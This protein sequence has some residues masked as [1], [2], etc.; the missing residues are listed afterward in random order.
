MKK[1][2]VAA[3]IGFH[4]TL[5]QSFIFG[6]PIDYFQGINNLPVLRETRYRHISSHDRVLG[7][8]GDFV[9]VKTGERFVLAE[10]QGPGIVT[11][12][13]LTF[14]CKDPFALR[15]VVLRMFWDGEKEPSVQSPIGDF[16]G[17]GFAEYVHFTSYLIGMSSGGFYSFFPMPFSKGAKIEIENNADTL[18]DGFYFNIGYQETKSLPKNM[19]RFH[20][21]WR[22]EKLSKKSGDYTILEARGRGHYVGTVLSMQG[23]KKG[24]L[25]FLE[26]DEKFYVDGE[27]VPSV[28]GTGTEDYFLSGYYFNKGTFGGPLH[29]CLIKDRENA[30]ISAYRFHTA[31]AI[32]FTKSIHVQIEHGVRT[33]LPVRA[34]YSSVAYWYQ[35]E[36]HRPFE[37]LPLPE[38]RIPLT[39]K[40]LGW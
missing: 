26:G 18:I 17:V 12:I 4:L 6:D 23:Y 2:M 31:D 3:L 14:T 35:Q 27:T 20:A 24:D 34:D 7:G 28:L 15:K 39:E 25:L 30:K 1:T 13:W 29:G 16:F 38:E 36:P 11:N 40:E 9:S 32:P 37:P 10:I 33:D 21:L 19:G 22:R 5:T 8:L